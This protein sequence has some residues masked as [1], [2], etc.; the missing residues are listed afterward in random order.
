MNNFLSHSP[1]NQPPLINTDIES[2]NFPNDRY[3]KFAEIIQKLGILE[4]TL[5][6]RHRLL[7]T[8]DLSP[9]ASVN[10]TRTAIQELKREMHDLLLKK[11][12]YPDGPCLMITQEDAK[13]FGIFHNTDKLEFR[14]ADAQNLAF[15]LE[16]IVRFQYE[17]TGHFINR[18]GYEESE[19]LA[20]IED[21][22]RHLHS[23]IQHMMDILTGRFDKP[24]KRRHSD[25]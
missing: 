10:K 24:R 21:T 18:G 3:K 20:M 5:R 4:E 11:H 12:S 19:R 25:D 6:T 15:Y 14:D 16:S 7:E 1:D 8:A 9:D 22:T 13:K 2:I 23:N 17:L